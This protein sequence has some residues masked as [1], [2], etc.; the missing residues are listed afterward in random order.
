[1]LMSSRFAKLV[2]QTKVPKY[3]QTS[4]F[5]RIGGKNRDNFSRVAALI[6][7]DPAEFYSISFLASI[8]ASNGNSE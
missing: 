8:P 1:M 3:V 6:Y 5:H 7:L 2:L 4:K